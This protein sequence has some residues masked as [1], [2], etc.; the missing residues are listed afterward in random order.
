MDM[1]VITLFLG[2]CL[3][4]NSALGSVLSASGSVK[5]PAKAVASGAQ[6]SPS[7]VPPASTVK[8]AGTELVTA[9][10]EVATEM[11]DP[12]FH[13]TP[14]K[15]PEAA[16]DDINSIEK[17]VKVMQAFKAKKIEEY[18]KN[19]VAL[20]ARLEKAEADLG[21]LKHND[22]AALKKLAYWVKVKAAIDG[23]KQLLIAVRTMP[24]RMRYP[25]EELKYGYQE[26]TQ[27]IKVLNDMNS[28]DKSREAVRGS[29]DAF[30][31][32]RN[33]AAPEKLE[34]LLTDARTKILAYYDLMIDLHKDFERML[35]GLWVISAKSF[36]NQ[37]E[38]EINILQGYVQK[39]AAAA[40]SATPAV[41]LTS[42][43][44]AVADGSLSDAKDFESRCRAIQE[45]EQDAAAKSLVA[46]DK[47][48]NQIEKCRRQMRMVW[49]EDGKVVDKTE[50]ISQ[51]KLDYEEA[52]ADE[53][54]ARR[55]KGKTDELIEA[56]VKVSN[57]RH[58]SYRKDQGR[59]DLEFS[60]HEARAA[61]EE[62]SSHITAIDPK[63]PTETESSR[64]GVTALLRES[65]LLRTQEYIQTNS[66]I[67]SVAVGISK[68][69]SRFK[70]MVPVRAEFEMRMRA[71]G[72][73]YPGVGAAMPIIRTVVNRFAPGM[74]E[75][76]A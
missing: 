59:E 13:N 38:E 28:N 46:I 23:E 70:D 44:A 1:R 73:I 60:L 51:R 75:S 5:L 17:L 34:A 9:G 56:F 2:S 74:I 76:W 29:L 7:V 27:T 26:A 25:I 8:E 32:Q 12:D 10:K 30:V 63:K 65:T 69:L 35:D 24:E 66:L 16:Q 71:V 11:A 41:E 19:I 64:T 67:G 61:L 49:K 39:S 20:Q 72:R 55:V 52:L 3:A 37:K 33:G 36:V 58:E 15:E 4:S 14:A 54:Q 31:A 45:K 21:E 62:A 57:Q 22:P 48:K 18:S 43:A 68:H 50:L 40:Q 53:E 6:T 42:S 47:Y